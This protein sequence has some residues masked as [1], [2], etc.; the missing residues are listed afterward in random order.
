MSYDNV[1]ERCGKHWTSSEQIDRDLCM[2][3]VI[4][5]MPMMT[6]EEYEEWGEYLKKRNADED[7]RS[8]CDD[9]EE[10]NDWDMSS[11]LSEET[12]VV[13]GHRYTKKPI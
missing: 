2:N 3:C 5:D 1:C 4:D 8:F 10:I 13:K 6:I 9:D 12:F 7:S 11:S